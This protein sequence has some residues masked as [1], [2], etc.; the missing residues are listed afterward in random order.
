LNIMGIGKPEAAVAAQPPLN[1]VAEHGISQ[2]V[3]PEL[4]GAAAWTW[5]AGAGGLCDVRLPRFVRTGFAKDAAFVEASH[6][7]SNSVI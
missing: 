2:T 3:A 4:V 1:L 7:V 6:F 5:E